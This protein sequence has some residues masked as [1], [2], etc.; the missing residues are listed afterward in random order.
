MAPALGERRRSLRSNGEP[1]TCSNAWL[2]AFA[3]S[4]RGCSSPY[5]FT[6][7]QA[8]EIGAP[9]RKEAKAAPAILFKKRLVDRDSA[10][11]PQTAK[12]GLRGT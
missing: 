7:R 1:F 12:P 2:L 9:V 6:F 4:V 10:M 3:G 5:W 8:L 11:I